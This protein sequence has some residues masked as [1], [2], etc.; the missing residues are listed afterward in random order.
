MAP[1]FIPASQRKTYLKQKRTLKYISVCHDPR[2]QRLILKKAPDSV[3][4]G[5]CNAVL[6]IAQNSDIQLPISIRKSLKRKRKFISNLVSP[7]V[8]IKRKRLLIQQ[9]GGAFLGF[10]LPAILS[11][12]FSLIGSKFL[13]G[14]N[15]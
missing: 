13:P 3:H 15:K 6:N 1:V 9:G 7:K 5:I 8:P 2:I 12:A 4:K 11:T 10:L 14:K